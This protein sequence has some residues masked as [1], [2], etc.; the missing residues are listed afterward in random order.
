M[1]QILHLEDSFTDRELVKALLDAEGIDC[2]IMAVETREE[3]V[4]HLG[5]SPW[6]LILSDNRL[7]AFNGLQALE[8]AKAT[9]PRTPF[10]FVTGTM[11]EDAAIESLENGATDYVLKQRMVR[12]GG[13]VRRALAESAEKQRLEQA[14]K[15]LHK[16]QEELRDSEEQLRGIFEQAAVGIVQTSAEGRI[17]RCNRRFAEI[18]GYPPGEIPGMTFQQIT[19]PEDLPESISAI[20]KLAGGSISS[21]AWEKR[22]V[23]K[24]GSYSW[25]RVTV[26][27][28]LDVA[29]RPIHYITVIEDIN[30][31]KAWEQRLFESQEALRISEESY[32]TIY[33]SSLVLNALT[34]L[35]DGVVV[36]ANKTFLDAMGFEKGEVIGHSTIDLHL[37][38]D[39]RDRKK[40][41]EMLQQHKEIRNFE[42]GLR[43]KNGDVFPVLLSASLI[44]VGGVACVLSV[45]QDISEMRAAED[46]LRQA[47]QKY[48]DIFE[49]A[50]EGI[51]QATKDGKPL[52]INPAGARLLGYASPEEATARVSES[53]NG[54]WL[55]PADRAHYTK[56]LKD[57]GQ[58]RNFSCQHK[59]ADGTPIWVSISARKICGPDGQMLYY[60][61]FMED[62]TEQ[63]RLET[64]LRAKIREL[65][66]LSEINNAL[67]RAKSEEELLAEY[68]RIIVEVGG[69]RMAWVGFAEDTP[70]KPI[71]PVAHFGQEDGYLKTLS[72]TWADTERGRGPVSR[73]I[74][75]GNVEVVE[76]VSTD[77][78]VS[79]WHETLKRGYRSIIATPFCH[80]D[81]SIACLTACGTTPRT[82]SEPE[83]KLMEQIG[84]ALGFG[85]KTLR[86]E[87]AKN[88][89]QENLRASLEETVRV[90][91]GTLEQRDPYTA[92][93]QRRV[94]DLCVQIAETMGLSADR[95]HGLKLAANIHD[96]GKNGI[97]S[98]L[99]TKPGLLSKAEFTLIMEHAELG[100]EIIKNVPFP[101]PIADMVRQH[102]ERIDGSGYP[103]GLKAEALLLESKILAVADVVEAM[104]SDR[105]YRRSRGIE[106]ALDEIL[107]HRGTQF[108][109]Q[110]VDACICLFREKGYKIPA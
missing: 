9:R 43:K 102:H 51:F 95:V 93:H 5:A 32:R 31:R 38:A 77:A 58:V 4:R 103:Q 25:A 71:V 96:L 34:R 48:R 65:Q 15:S 35:S 100:Y 45:M 79:S 21:A 13:S 14:E 60:Q 17:L 37:W 91:A 50:P 74:R 22:F 24:D 1:I 33:Q 107:A 7:P 29:G 16:S 82:W 109:P 53:A 49:D 63:A 70:G 106:A 44:D 90:V 55:N 36:D 3:F 26:S 27:P 12:L 87:I 18:V 101:W 57:Q 46:A 69:Y 64:A 8:I 47:D 86:T 105:P 40:F 56:L 85:I 98:E 84:L 2:Q 10:I 108:D 88:E 28:Q 68:C 97:P 23:R 92:G 83:R 41:T 39:V 20:E 67:L 30:A 80:A 62:M 110:V 19:A 6:D 52:T 104:G 59:R 66:L 81:G 99:L 54:I 78:T 94:A 89:F 61:G 42:I 76:D 11:G 73:A 75:S 72:P